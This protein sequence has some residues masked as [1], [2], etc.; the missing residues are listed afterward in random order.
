MKNLIT[1]TCF[2]FFLLSASFSQGWE[3]EY[4]FG[5]YESISKLAVLPTGGVIAGARWGAQDEFKLFAVDDDGEL[6]WQK[7]IGHQ[8]PNGLDISDLLISTDTNIIMITLTATTFNPIPPDTITAYGN[9]FFIHKLDLLGNQIWEKELDIAHPFYSDRTVVTNTHDGNLLVMSS[10]QGELIKINL[11]GDILWSNEIT[12]PDFKAGEIISSPDNSFIIVGQSGI[13]GT[14]GGEDIIVIKIDANGN[15]IWE[16]RYEHEN[17]QW[18]R[19]GIIT[20]DDHI[21]LGGLLFPNMAGAG[22]IDFYLLKLDLDGNFIWEITY[23]DLMGTE[24]IGGLTELRNGDYAIIGW[25]DTFSTNGPGHGAVARRV[26]PNGNFVSDNYYSC[27]NIYDVAQDAS[28]NIYMGAL[29]TNRNYGLP[30]SANAYIIKSDSN[31]VSRS[32]LIQGNISK[33]NDFDCQNSANDYGL[34]NWFINLS[35]DFSNYQLSDSS[36]DFSFRV[37]TGNYYVKAIPPIPYWDLCSTI[38]SFTFNNEFD[39]VN[40]EISAQANIEC[41]WME[42]SINTPILRR[43]SDSRYY[44]QYCNHGTLAADSAFIR[45]LLD[46]FLNIFDASIPY[47]SLGGNVYLFELGLVGI[48][49]CGQFT[50]DAEVSCN[51]ALGQTHCVEAHIYPDSLCLPT[52]GW[53][54][55]SIEVSGICV[56][57]SIHFNIKNTGS[58]PTSQPLEYIVIEDDVIL[59][60]DEIAFLG[61]GEVREIIIENTGATYRMEAEQEPNHPGNSHPTYIIEGCGQGFTPGFVNIFPMNDA[62]PFIDIDCRQNIGSYDPND[63]LAFP[64]GVHDEHFIKQNTDI[65]YM[66]RFQNTGTDTAFRVV[67]RDTL[68]PFLDVASVR[69][70]ASSHPYEFDI[71]GP[72]VLKFTFNDILLPDSSANEAASHGFIKYRISQKENVPLG[73]EINNSAAIYFDFNAPVITNT[74]WHTVGENFVEI[75]VSVNN[76]TYKNAAVNIYPNPFSK[77]ATVELKGLDMSGESTFLLY[78]PVGHLMQQYIFENN[79]LEINGG[80]L[81]NGVYI[82]QIKNEGG[83]VAT[84]KVVVV[85]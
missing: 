14:V 9:K 53:A 69:P 48:G 17:S 59:Y 37:E 7:E 63:K 61:I 28:G 19:E 84:G 21:L 68:S 57:D 34:K 4:D 32:N 66:I 31:L 20:S 26:S 72:G 27:E 70:G 76:K 42:V 71:S 49:Q 41:P 35:G 80:H 52:N 23:P 73:S 51:A 79:K 30:Q 56:G 3:R 45:V 55:A 85:E 62:D 22:S 46:P 2:F 16:K 67:I 11:D 74:T 29:Y 18:I 60:E 77:T 43:C 10:P 40:L 47:T 1:T 13:S 81:P 39:T 50:F 82:F 36:G 54:G 83:I 6:V 44:V 65:E 78:D 33:D 58:A 8:Q 5:D 75:F 64:T 38:D 25:S 24:D 12:I 15:L